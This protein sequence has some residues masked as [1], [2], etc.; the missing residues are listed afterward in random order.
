[1]ALFQIVILAP[2]LKETRE[3]T[4]PPRTGDRIYSVPWRFDRHGMTCRASTRGNPDVPQ[5]AMAT[6]MDSE[7]GVSSLLRCIGAGPPHVGNKSPDGV[8]ENASRRSH[9]RE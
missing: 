5:I 7:N 8:G 3:E 1:M 6:P 9:C 2:Q 4:T